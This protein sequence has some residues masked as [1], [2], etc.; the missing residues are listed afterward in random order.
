MGMIIMW[1]CTVL[2]VELVFI[3]GN[4][5]NGDSLPPGD[6]GQTELAEERK[7]IQQVLSGTPDPV[8]CIQNEN[9]TAPSNVNAHI[10]I[11]LGISK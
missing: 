1:T 3:E 11:N 10:I 2:Y 5:M 9:V 4:G 7:V 8:V 6:T